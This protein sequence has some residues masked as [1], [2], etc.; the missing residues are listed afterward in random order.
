MKIEIETNISNLCGTSVHINSVKVDPSDFGVFSKTT[1]SEEGEV[2]CIF[3]FAGK[4]RFDDDVLNK[5]DIYEC[6]AYT[7][8]RILQDI[9]HGNTCSG[10]V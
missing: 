7:V 8:A 10:C 3:M 9:F 2:Q 1:K 6:E 4:Q 5:Y